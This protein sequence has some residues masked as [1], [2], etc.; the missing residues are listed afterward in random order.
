MLKNDQG[1]VLIITYF[2][3]VAILGLSAITFMRA[4][5]ENRLAQ[6]SSNSLE[7][8]Y[9]A[10]AGTAYAYA[11]ASLQGFTWYTHEDKD[12]PVTFSHDV[13]DDFGSTAHFIFPVPTNLPDSSIATSGNY[14][15]CYQVAGKD[16]AVK[17]YPEKDS[18][19]NYTG[20]VIIL[21]QGQANGVLRTIEYRL[22]QSSAYQFFFFYPDSQTFSSTTINGRNYGA[23]HVNGSILLT[24]TPRFYFL[25]ELTCGSRTEG[26]GYIC[27]PL[28]Q[29]FYDC[30]GNVHYDTSPSDPWDLSYYMYR[31]TTRHFYT[32]NTYFRTGEEGSYTQVTLRYYLEGSDAS[33]EFDKYEGEQGDSNDKLPLHYDLGDDNLQDLATYE[34]VKG[35]GSVGLLSDSGRMR[36]QVPSIGRLEGTEENIF[37]E[38][39]NYDFPNQ[40]TEEEAWKIFWN[41]W[42]DN[43][44]NDYQDYHADGTLIS[45]SDWERKFYFA[46]YDWSDGNSR[47]P[48]NGIPDGINKEWWE[49]LEYG[50]D[51]PLLSDDMVPAEVTSTY[52]GEGL[53][54]YFLNTEE[55]ASSW[56][57]WLSANNLDEKGNQKTLVQD[58]SQGGQY[59]DPGKILS[60]HGDYDKNKE[61]AKEAGIYIGLDG[62]DFSNPVANCTRETQF[63]N[64]QRPAKSDGDYKPSNVLVID[65][66]ELKNKIEEDMPDFN[67]IVYVDLAGYNWSS[68]HYDAEADGVMLV[69][70]ETLP[71]SGLSIV[72]PNNVFI[73]GNYNLDPT[74][75]LE[76]NREPDDSGVIQRVIDSRDYLD[77]ESDLEW[78]PTEV[79]TSRAV[80]TLSDDFNEPDYMPMAWSHNQQYYDERDYMPEQDYVSGNANYPTNGWVPSP[81]DTTREYSR[82]Y[83]WFRYYE[84]GQSLPSEWDASWIYSH[85]PSN[86]VFALD[87]NRDHRADT[88]IMGRDL[89]N[90]VYNHIENTYDSKYSY[91]AVH[92]ADGTGNPDVPSQNNRVS[93]KH[94]YNVAIVTPYNTFPDAL[95]YWGSTDRIING[96][97]IQLP[98]ESQYMDSVPS[99]ARYSRYDSPDNFFNYET[100]YGQG[101]DPSDRPP[102]GLT[103]GL[104]ASWRELNNESF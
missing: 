16:F 62:E 35:S 79:I 8:F 101:A 61:K 28:R 26:E 17:S 58:K 29:Q 98:D 95:E 64:S 92:G 5:S 33:W 90:D 11:E 3:L 56:G 43:H 82:V 72:T 104:T 20:N 97:F 85:W 57:N 74:G 63:Y 51:R 23:I 4:V 94:I 27:R 70:G 100:R 2:V 25:T 21:S 67:G 73:K 15:S 44:V 93:D 46:A 71:D 88:Y 45:G 39:Y 65:V 52:T 37:E 9:A 80:Y 54:R 60:A 31:D 49:D 7:A 68:T 83:L 40:G 18:L 59:V 102:V 38:M 1:I 53:D 32:G 14:Q 55:Q 24:G 22:G 12:T 66:Q 103:F 81:R 50:T 91:E 41:Q 10:E 42:K 76:K 34:M 84:G 78:Q 69:N 77:S 19:G 13:T 99:N 87:T 96:A 30:R 89:R 6:R 48:A 36:I 47:H 86:K 75:E